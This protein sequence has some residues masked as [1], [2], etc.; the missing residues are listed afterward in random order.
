MRAASPGS[1]SSHRRTHLMGPRHSNLY[2]AAYRAPREN[3]Q[4]AHLPNS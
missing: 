4:V 2:P 1:P 3:T